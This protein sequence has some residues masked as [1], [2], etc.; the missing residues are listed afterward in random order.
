MGI[1]D[2][3]KWLWDPRSEDEKRYKTD[4]LRKHS[5]KLKVYLRD[6]EQPLEI[7]FTRSDFQTGFGP[8][9]YDIDYEVNR[10]LRGRTSNGIQV[11][12]VWYSPN[13]IERIEL[14]EKTVEEIS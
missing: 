14:G 3:L 7:T 12:G 13:Q 10:W 11:D 1:I 6:T 4:P 5:Q 9:R 8:L 2:T